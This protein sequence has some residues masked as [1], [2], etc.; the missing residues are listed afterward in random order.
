MPTVILLRHGR[1]TA[2]ASGTLAG[3]TP[4]VH[5]DSTGLRQAVAAAEAIAAVR[6]PALVACSPLDRCRETAHEVITRTGAQLEI[7]EDLGECRYGSWTNRSIADLTQEPLWSAVQNHPS[8]VT[9][10]PSQDYASESMA[11]MQQRAVQAIRTLDARVAD[12]H[13]ADAVWVAVSHGDV[14]KSII[15]DACG[16][17]LDHFQ[18]IIV[19]PASLSVI[20]YTPQRP[21]VIRTNETSGGLRDI[22][23]SRL[24]SGQDATV[25]GSTGADPASA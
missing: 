17:H 13:G 16:S 15:A 25:G 1:T 4:G 18:R 14:I 9:F 5:L 8:S 6:T 3:W 22:L 21:F 20:T 23:A 10:P 2:N 19:A 12:E 24:T 7:V 11:A